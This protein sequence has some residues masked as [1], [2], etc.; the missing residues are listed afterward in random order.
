MSEAFP[1]AE[2]K[3]ALWLHSDG[4]ARPLPLLQESWERR[5]EFAV[6]LLA[7]FAQQSR[8]PIKSSP[9][10][11]FDFYHDLVL[12]HVGL[13]TPAL[14]APRAPLQPPQ[15]ESFA[16][17]HAACSERAAAWQ[18]AGVKAGDSL[19]IVGNLGR[20]LLLALLCG[21]RL[22]LLITLLPALGPDYLRSR[23]HRLKPSYVAL[24]PHY[25]RLLPDA[26][27]V[28][29]ILP[30]AAPGAQV[31]AAK[32]ALGSHT[33]EA[34]QPVFAL[35][36]PLRAPA[37]PPLPLSAGEAYVAAVRDGLLLLRLTAGTTLAAPDRP[38]LEQQPALLLCTLLH[39]GTF[40]HDLAHESPPAGGPLPSAQ[41]LFVSRTLRERLL[42]RPPRPLSALRLWLVHP[43]EAADRRW[44]DFAAHTGLASVPAMSAWVD[45]SV[46][47][48][49]LFSA[50]RLGAPSP[51]LLPAPGL[52]F[53]LTW[54]GNPK[55]PA[56]AGAGVLRSPDGDAAGLGIHLAPLD[57]GY[58]YGGSVEP[59]HQGARYPAAEVEA[60]V[61]KLP[62]VDAALV[63]LA[64]GRQG[65]P[66]LFVFLGP[67]PLDIAKELAA[68]RR[69]AIRDQLSSRLGA[70]FVPAQIE[71]LAMYPRRNDEVL[72][73]AWL[74]RIYQEGGLRERESQPLFRLLDRLRAAWSGP[75]PEAP[76]TADKKGMRP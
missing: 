3:R 46:A 54:A 2:L 25:R 69:A 63:Q 74:Q 64:A 38:L 56:G 11:G 6:A 39:G 26:D 70:E 51:Q 19:C 76:A 28:G 9:E 12:R 18:V 4:I 41:I 1:I 32:S 43:S 23:L 61:G 27:W 33:Y 37:A 57:A 13:Q 10:A 48:C 52:S 59:L 5:R 17:L 58:I 60:V 65:E 68:A 31:A 20:E 73:R 53:S 7:S 55:L 36:S 24:E 62:F 40:L 45:A 22:G 67:E 14:I 21:L 71:L 66:I 16:E 47:G 50:P 8:P 75:L 34:T 29:T 15:A 30:Q 42:Q 35:Y 49:L 44:L 72:D